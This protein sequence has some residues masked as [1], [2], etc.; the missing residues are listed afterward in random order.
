MI[1]TIIPN[2][3]AFLMVTPYSRSIIRD[4]KSDFIIRNLNPVETSGG[5]L[6]GGFKV[7]NFI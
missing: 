7:R 3:F 6:Q 2:I 5:I 4:L 1:V